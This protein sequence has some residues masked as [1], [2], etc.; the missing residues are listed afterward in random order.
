MGT[1]MQWVL[2]KKYNWKG[3]GHT[4]VITQNSIFKPVISMHNLLEKSS[5]AT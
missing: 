4:K 3:K 5:I 1:K 2:K